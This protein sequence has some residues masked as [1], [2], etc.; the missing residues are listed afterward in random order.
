MLARHGVEREARV[1]LLMTDTVDLPTAFWGAIKA[2]VAPAP[3]NTL[4]STE[5]Y[6]VILADSRAKALIVSKE[7]LPAVAPL[8]PGHP[9][10]RAVFVAGGE[11]PAGTLDFEAE[12][13]R[14]EPRPTHPPRPT[15]ARSGCFPRARPA[16]R[17]ASA[18][19]TA[20]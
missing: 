10:L 11:G 19:P 14:S 6:R 7:L 20:A 3:L 5:L 18:T 9:F 16:S 12:L 13:A 15:N 4:L 1:A 17:K 2:G 8:L